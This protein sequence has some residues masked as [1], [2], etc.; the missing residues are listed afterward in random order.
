MMLSEIT[1]L[2]Y[3]LLG[4]MG[5]LGL[6]VGLILAKVA[7]EEL[8]D[9]K[10]Y[11]FWLQRIIFTAAV[12]VVIIFLKLYEFWGV[13]VALGVILVLFIYFR[14]KNADVFYYAICALLFY[15]SAF[16]TPLLEITTVLVFFLG[17][18]TAALIYQKSKN[19][20][21]IYLAKK[22]AIKF[23]FFLVLIV[24]FWFVF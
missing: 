12:L 18:P 22:T 7:E 17:Y 1:F 10:K 3:L 14:K 6:L 11:F 23:S 21:L 13:L 15:L 8:N 4:V 24:L 20:N 9:G 19:K 2:S 5:F 16:K